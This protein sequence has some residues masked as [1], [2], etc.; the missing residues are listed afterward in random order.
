VTVVH[1]RRAA[2]AL[3]ALVLAAASGCLEDRPRPAPPQLHIVIT[4]DSIVTSDSVEGVLRVDDPDGIDS[5]WLAVDS[6]TA[7]VDGLFQT[8][9]QSAFQFAIKPSHSPGEHVPVVLSARDVT[10]FTSTLD[11]FVVVKLP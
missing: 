10:G 2:L 11:T 5:A 7:G 3:G 8:T 6:V 1:R 9:V 4:H